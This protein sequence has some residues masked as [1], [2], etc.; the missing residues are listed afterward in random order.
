MGYITRF[1]SFWGKLPE[2]SGR[3]F[4][5]APGASYTVEGR[6]YA[7]SDDNDGLSPERAFLTIDYAVGQTTA[8]V[9]DVI[10]LLP[11]S[12][13]V[14]ATVTLDVAGITIT[15]IPG[16]IPH[17]ADRSS[18]SGS[19]CRSQVTTSQA[20]GNIFTLTGAGD[21]I[22]IAYIHFNLITQGDGIII[23]LGA[24]RPYIHDCTFAATGTASSTS[25]CIHFS[26]STTGSV[27]N[28]LIRNCYFLASGNQGPA[29]RALGTVLGLTIESCTFQLMGTAAWDDAIEILDAGT[30]GTLIRDCDFQEPTNA[31]TVIT[32]CIDVTGVTINGATHIYRC[33][34]T[35]DDK[36]GVVATATPDILV[37]DCWS[38]GTTAGRNNVQAA[39]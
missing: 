5:V 31:T 32:N 27:S 23:P 3:L 28:A 22:E 25:E 19:R 9:G 1:G 39:A 14:T 30:L 33:Y 4:W 20:A 7:A 11:G 6:T 18:G 29:I 38:A 17:H 34:F 26:S 35:G 24:D 10:V 2:T 37:S 13:T 8:S 16:A 36:V 12:H 15:G 21:D